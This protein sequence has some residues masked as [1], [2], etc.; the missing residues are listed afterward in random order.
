[1]FKKGTI[2]LIPFPFTDLTGTKV[3]PALIV[4]SN[5]LK[6]EDIVLV[7]ISSLKTKNLLSTDLLITT[8]HK[9]FKQTGLK[10]ES[11]LKIDKIA[12]LDKKI[13][14]GELGEISRDIQKEVD[15]KLKI[16][17]GL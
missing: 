11:I 10:E 12:T 4:S 16:V 1:M 9:D 7:F 5:V 2:V 14:L 8:S 6:G 17:F 3:R 15:Q 13:I